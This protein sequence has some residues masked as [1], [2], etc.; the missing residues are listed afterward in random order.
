MMHGRG[1]ICRVRAMKPETVELMATPH[2]VSTGLASPRLGHEG[3]LLDQS[4]PRLLA[5]RLRHGGF[6]GTV[7]WIDPDWSLR[8]LPDNR[9]H[10]GRQGPREPVGRKIGTLVAARL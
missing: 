1:A 3:R 7:L 10:S 6:T 4:W 5:A 8:Y 9:V 2:R